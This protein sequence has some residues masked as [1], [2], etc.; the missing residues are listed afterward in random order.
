MTEY[1]HDEGK[2]QDAV[3]RLAAIV[4]SAEDAVISKSPDGII[5]TWNPGA[6]LLFGYR[7]ADVI[8]KPITLLIPADRQ[9]EERDIINKAL[10]GERVKAY[11][12][13]RLRADGRP[14]DISLTV[15]P[16][17]NDNGEIIGISSIARD[18]SAHKRAVEALRR[19][20]EELHVLTDAL[21][22]LIAYVDSDLRYGFV[23]LAYESWFGTP[24]QRLLGEAM[25]SALR[26]PAFRTIEP[27]LHRAL[28]GEAVR[29]ETWLDYPRAGRR[30]IDASLIPRSDAKGQPIGFFALVSDITD[31]VRAEEALRRKEDSLH[32]AQKLANLGSYDYDL[33]TGHVTWSPQLYDMFSLDPAGTPLSIE[34]ALTCVH[35]D[36][37]PRVRAALHDTMDS[38]TP[39]DLEL[40]L[41]CN[42][43]EHIVLT[44]GEVVARDPAG[45]ATRFIGTVMEITQR[46]RMEIE[47]GRAQKLES[48]G[49]LAGGIAHDFN[50]L[51]TALFGNIELAR[52]R[53]AD[54]PEVAELLTQAEKA[55][56]RARA[57]TRQ[58]LTFARGGAPVRRIAVLEPI[59][60]DNISFALRGS[61]IDIEFAIAQDLHPANVDIDQ[62]GQAISNIVINAREAMPRGG[63]LRVSANNVNIQEGNAL[64]LAPGPYVKMTFDDSGPGVEPGHLALIFDPY[65]STKPNG[66]GLGLPTAYSIVKRHGGLITAHANRDSGARFC[67]YLPASPDKV[68]AVIEAHRT[69]QEGRGRVLLMDDEPLLRQVGR[70]LADKLGYQ[71]TVASDGQE[72]IQFYAEAQA[73]GEPFAAVILD[74]TVPGGMG[75]LE[76]L[77]RLKE[78]DPN[79][80][81]I[82]SSG[83]ATDAILAQY[84]Q[85]GF[86]AVVAKP[87]RLDEL[88]NALAVATGTPPGPNVRKM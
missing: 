41:L 33:T 7:A 57:L 74:L 50:N 62:I 9:D 25:S 32:R 5:Q 87:Y 1:A 24:R 77:E 21:P 79:V 16:I 48:I 51:L 67:L 40:R 76:C 22:V 68:P 28:Q 17:R 4:E 26:P 85:H 52:M 37:R 81:A 38:S 64:G 78:V 54:R 47:A 14:V 58:L 49:H 36:D 6:A 55:F 46:K 84:Q 86:V 39:F 12:T 60:V 71:A 29:F 10:A 83:Y 34:A 61:N 72:C 70:A 19:R 45:K 31:H 23:N 66:T 3:W 59:L 15:S 63:R 11:E 75:G 43:K 56:Q 65:F 35:P 42:G 69:I 53:V 27:Y 20:E 82:V 2:S 44:Q 88:G 13:V 8:G 73:R 18:I 80:R 30:Y